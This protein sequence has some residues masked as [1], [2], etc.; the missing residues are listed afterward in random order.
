[1]IHYV[2]IRSFGATDADKAV[3]EFGR[4]LTLI[5]GQNGAGKTV[6]YNGSIR[7]LLSVM[8][9]LSCTVQ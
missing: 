8:D 2:G 6:N 7:Q 4:P 1:M 3:I 9:Q 5:T